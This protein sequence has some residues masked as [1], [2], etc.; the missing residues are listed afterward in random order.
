MKMTIVI[1]KKSGKY[2][3]GNEDFNRLSW[4]I[5]ARS[6]DESRLKINGVNFS[7]GVATATDG[8]RLHM[9]CIERE[10]PDGNYIV[11]SATGKLI[12]LETDTAD[13]AYPDVERVW[14]KRQGEYVKTVTT[15]S[16]PSRFIYEVYNSGDLYNIKYLNDVYMPDTEMVIDIEPNHKRPAVFY[17]YRKDMAA[18]LMP[19][20]K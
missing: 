6:N 3:E 8:H 18:L 13:F 19:L 10:I 16:D 12:V 14:R 15:N 7:C 1:E 2:A 11:K 4:V 20:M 5:K 17:N 9:A